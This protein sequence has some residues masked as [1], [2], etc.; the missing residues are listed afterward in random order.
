MQTLSSLCSAG[1]N[2]GVPHAEI[3][4]VID[5]FRPSVSAL[6]KLFDATTAT[7]GRTT[8]QV[9]LAQL[10]AKREALEQARYEALMAAGDAAH[11]DDDEE[12]DVEAGRAGYEA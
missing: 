11:P 4:R 3:D 12:D 7:T 6:A 1:P 8:A 2:A 9:Q 10:L 5:L